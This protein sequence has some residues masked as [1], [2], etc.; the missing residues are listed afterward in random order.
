LIERI[1]AVSQGGTMFHITKGNI[2]TRKFKFPCKDEQQKIA[3]FLS[4]L[5]VKIESVAAQIAHTQT[6]K[7]GLLQQM[8]V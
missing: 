4:A 7:K 5:D 8:F 1:K 6:F 3:S 2:E